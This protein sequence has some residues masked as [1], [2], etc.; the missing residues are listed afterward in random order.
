MYDSKD[1]ENSILKDKVK[2]LE[3]E[4]YSLKN[5]IGFGGLRGFDGSS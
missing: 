5:P 4:I 1:H 2:L 3:S